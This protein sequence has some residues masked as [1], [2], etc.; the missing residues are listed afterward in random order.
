MLHQNLPDLPRCTPAGGP[1]TARYLIAISLLTAVA[2]CGAS[3][4]RGF[5]DQGAVPSTGNFFEVPHTVIPKN[6]RPAGV[7]GDNA[8]QAKTY[9]PEGTPAE[10]WRWL[11]VV[12]QQDRATAGD[13]DDA[14]DKISES[15]RQ[16]C[17]GKLV[18]ARPDRF[19]DDGFPA[20]TQT[21]S[22]G[23]QGKQ[24]S[25]TVVIYKVIAGTKAVHTMEF[26][27]RTQKQADG[28]AMQPPAAE[29]AIATAAL[30]QMHICNL[31]KPASYCTEMGGVPAGSPVRLPQ[32]PPPPP[33]PAPG[34]TSRSGSH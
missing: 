2:A 27:W 15:L 9:L 8:L 24:G 22:C 30:G 31:L 11:L 13:L 7:V 29:M 16:P 20:A 17:A 10:S 34:P 14:L 32:P 12:L 21:A 4:P 5:G 1:R 3:H 26:V 25:A 19:P 23:A 6:F 33:Q 28:T 18:A